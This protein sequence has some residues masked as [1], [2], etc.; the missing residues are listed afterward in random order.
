MIRK[1]WISTG[2]ALSMVAIMTLGVL[3]SSTSQAQENQ[4]SGV[5]RN[6][7]T[8]L[9]C[10]LG[11]AVLGISTLSFYGQPQ[12]HI[13]NITTGLA[14]GTI[15]GVIYVTSTQYYGSNGSNNTTLLQHDRGIELSHQKGNNKPPMMWSWN[16]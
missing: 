15:A 14:L 13:G 11:G 12:E 8:I 3:F 16:F 10:G 7:A 9:F 5:R 2:L 4:F 6:L 1:S